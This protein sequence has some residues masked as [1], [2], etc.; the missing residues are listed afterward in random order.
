MMVIIEVILEVILPPT[1]I[2]KGVVYNPPQGKP[3]GDII[4]PEN[5]PYKGARA[6]C[7]HPSLMSYIHSSDQGRTEQLCDRAELLVKMEGEHPILH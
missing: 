3:E 5:V 1:T 6:D 7:E 4:N 2:H